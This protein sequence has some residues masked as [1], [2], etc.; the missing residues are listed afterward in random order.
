MSNVNKERQPFLAM[1]GITAGSA[2]NSLTDIIFGSVTITCPSAAAS[3][4]QANT[5]TATGVQAGAKLFVTAAS[6][7][8][9][10]VLVSA[11]VTAVNTISASF[12]NSTTANIATSALVTLQY[13]AVA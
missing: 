2:G 10:F 12:L 7:P 3:T 13:L 9:G 8:Q 11:S 1:S 4:A 6:V 5:A